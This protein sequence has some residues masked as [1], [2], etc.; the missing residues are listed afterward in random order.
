MKRSIQLFT[1]AILVSISFLAINAQEQTIVTATEDSAATEKVEK[2][3]STKKQSSSDDSWTG[4]YVGGFGG[5]SN[6]R[7]KPTM[8]TPIDSIGHFSSANEQ[9]VNNTANPKLSSN[10]FS[11]GG[12][13][14]YNYQKGQ[15]FIGGEVDLGVNKIN[16]SGSVTNGFIEGGNAKFTIT[17]SVKSNW[18]MTARPRA[19]V[20]LK[21]ALIYGTVGLALADV[22]YD[23]LY[24]DFT[25]L[26]RTANGGVKKTVTGWNAGGGVEVKVDRHWSLKGEYLYN[27]FSKTT[28][29][30]NNL[31]GISLSGNKTTTPDEF[32]NYS[33]D[34][35]S[36][37]IRF[38]VN[39]RF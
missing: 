28:F 8:T 26:A 19:G 16:K 20:A 39:Y 34:L 17:H 13:F 29:T 4:F 32:F 21:K 6:N 23:G 27:Q 37:S 9:I 33:T 10:N 24:S 35:K 5:F 3:E 36:H 11:G 12:T 7:A 18:Q 38:G 1:I 22:N 30:A 31:N 25:V 15:F 14:G 2:K